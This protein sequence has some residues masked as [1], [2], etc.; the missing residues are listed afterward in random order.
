MRA[1]ML[2]MKANPEQVVNA[3]SS[4]TQLEGVH[5]PL[6]VLSLDKQ[7]SGSLTALNSNFLPNPCDL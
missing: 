1:T 2:G 3:M 5:L 6:I 7:Y 4:F